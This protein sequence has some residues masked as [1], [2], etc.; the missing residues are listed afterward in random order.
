MILLGNLLAALARIFHIILWVYMWIIIIRAILSWI[1]VPSL[2]PLVVIL[3]RLTEPALRP[4]RRI[5]PP[6]RFGGIDVAPMI[7]ILIIIFIDSFLVRSIAIY[8]QRLLREG[9]FYF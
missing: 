4:L 1:N 3:H 9:R 7:A 2:Y 5:I 8:A 6:S